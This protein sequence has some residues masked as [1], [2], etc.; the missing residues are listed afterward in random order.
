MS[1]PLPDDEK[2]TAKDEWL[3]PHKAQIVSRLKH[4]TATAHR[5]LGDG[6][7][8]DFAQGHTYFG[9]HQPGISWVIREWAPYATK[10]YVVGEF[11]DW[12]DD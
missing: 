8:V 3:R 4:T 1:T 5:I 7:V 2:L 12:K 10:V 11:S 9:L 6:N